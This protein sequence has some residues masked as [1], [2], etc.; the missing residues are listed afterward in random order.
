MGLALT[1]PAAHASSPGP[2]LCVPGGCSQVFPRLH[3]LSPHHCPAPLCP[4]PALRTLCLLSGCLAMIGA[5]RLG[6]RRSPLVLAEWE[7]GR[8]AA[9]PAVPGPFFVVCLVVS[10][11]SEEAEEMCL[12]WFSDLGFF[13]LIY[14]PLPCVTVSLLSFCL[15][16]A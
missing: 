7:T 4:A 12:V 16:L 2:R 1:P 6:M 9:A 13:W 5:G 14:L 15:C 11:K 10:V 8:G 3:V